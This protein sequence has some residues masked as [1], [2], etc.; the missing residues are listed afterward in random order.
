MAVLSSALAASFAAVE[1]NLSAITEP[2]GILSNSDDR[3]ADVL[4][5]AF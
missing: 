2:N 1:A 5:H 4:I 3:P